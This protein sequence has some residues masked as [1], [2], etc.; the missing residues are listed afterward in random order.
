MPNLTIPRISQLNGRNDRTLMTP[1]SETTR[2]SRRLPEP[3]LRVAQR[4][5]DT[6]ENFPSM[7]SATLARCRQRVPAAD[8]ALNIVP[9]HRGLAQ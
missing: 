5:H 6:M 7:L 3:A 9:R 2:S 4:G 1:R 8:Q